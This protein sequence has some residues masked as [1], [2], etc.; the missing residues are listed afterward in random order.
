MVFSWATIICWFHEK[1][2]PGYLYIAF[3]TLFSLSGSR[4][5]VVSEGAEKCTAC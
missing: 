1:I 3:Y 5:L 2:L 4:A